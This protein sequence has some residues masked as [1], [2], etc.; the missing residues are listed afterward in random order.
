MIYLWEI[1]K[2]K[3][4]W[5]WNFHSFLRLK[6]YFI[7]FFCFFFILKWWNWRLNWAWQCNVYQFIINESKLIFFFEANKKKFV[8]RGY[9]YVL[10]DNG[11]KTPNNKGGYTWQS[12]DEDI[13]DSSLVHLCSNLLFDGLSII[14]DAYCLVSHWRNFG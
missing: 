1:W 7:G 4:N 9:L 13:D 8:S 10:Y 12:T 3:F 5:F 6:I 11:N 14:T 2:E